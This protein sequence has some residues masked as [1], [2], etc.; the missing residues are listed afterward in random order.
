MVS[1]K[2]VVADVFVVFNNSHPF[3]S[4]KATVRVRVHHLRAH[5]F[6]LCASWL[7]SFGGERGQ[8]R[9]A[10]PPPFPGP[11]HTSALQLGFETLDL[12]LQRAHFLALVAHLR[13]SESTTREIGWGERG[14]GGGQGKV[15][16]ESIIDRRMAEFDLSRTKGRR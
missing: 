2:P 11:Q 5:G 4:H 3:Q 14:A 13:A 15:A 12:R 6:D 1:I 9:L 10:I 8:Q 16:K 7:H